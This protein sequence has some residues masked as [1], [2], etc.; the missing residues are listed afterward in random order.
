[1]SRKDK[2]VS[3]TILKREVDNSNFSLS[4]QA[5]ISVKSRPYSSKQT[6]KITDDIKSPT[7]STSQKKMG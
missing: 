4:R 2:T 1:M 6:V 5:K 3:V 7:T